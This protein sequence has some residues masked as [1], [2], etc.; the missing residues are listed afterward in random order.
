MGDKG[1]RKISSELLVMSLGS[2]YRGGRDLP[3]RR[4]KLSRTCNLCNQS[5]TVHN[6]ILTG[7]ILYRRQNT[8]LHHTLRIQLVKQFKIHPQASSPALNF[9]YKPL[10]IAP[11]RYHMCCKEN[12]WCKMRTLVNTADIASHLSMCRRGMSLHRSVPMLAQ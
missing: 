10:R 2:L 8:N 11:D 4:R 3:H 1:C 12:L 6:P 5:N 9:P 7:R